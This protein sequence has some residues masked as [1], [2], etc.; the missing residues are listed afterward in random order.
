MN[1]AMNDAMNDELNVRDGIGKALEA[2]RAGRA[3]RAIELLEPLSRQSPRDARVWQLLGFASRD[4]QRM[5]EAAQAFAQAVQRH[6]KDAK[7]VLAHAQARYESGLPAAQLCRQALELDPDNLAAIGGCA[8][9]LAAEDQKRAAENLLVDTLARR[10]DWLEGHKALSALRW[11]AGDTEEFVRSYTAACRK[12]PQHVPLR[13][14][15]FRQVAQA[16]N[17]PAALAIIE[18]GERLCGA[19]PAFVMARLFIAAESG[20]RAQAEALFEHTRDWRDEVRD[21][22]WIRHCLRERRP[23]EA[24]DVALALTRTPSA[25]LAWPYLSLIWR[26]LEDPRALW[27]DGSPPYARAMEVDLTSADLAEFAAL[28]RRLHTARAP[29]IEQSVRGGTQTDRPLFFRAEPI[30][31]RVRARL[32][33]AIREYVAGLPPFVEG[34]PLLGTP[35]T[36][37]LFSGSWSVRLLS[38]GYNVAHTHPMGWISSAFYVSLPSTAQ[39]GP[40]PAGW[41]RFGTPPPELGLDLPAYAQIEP[42]PGR[43]ALFP[44]TLWHSTVPFDDGERLVA[45]FDVR[46]PAY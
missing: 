1:H 41:I 37:L 10:P 44:S 29:Y 30:V 33:D 35:R 3:D 42:R 36:Q 31:Q 26:L 4:E 5:P 20:A 12:L 15:W 13:L 25:R 46:P 39:M 22:A 28:L 43:L 23:A 11:T 17:W 9:A 21:L 6:P 8:A 45:A 38:Q 40:A 19:Q 18:A 16:R 34:H 32:L 27:L 2:M 14:A 24:A 7:S